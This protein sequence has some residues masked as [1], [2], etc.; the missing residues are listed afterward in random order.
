M[1]AAQLAW[2]EKQMVRRTTPPL[3]ITNQ[4]DVVLADEQWPKTMSFWLVMAQGGLIRQTR[5]VN[6]L[7]WDGV[8]FK[9]CSALFILITSF[10]FP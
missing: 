9:L 6:P 4:N 10:S 5:A 1:T 2:A 7:G 3:A 8:M